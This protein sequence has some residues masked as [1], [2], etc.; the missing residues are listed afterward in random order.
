VRKEEI[1]H[2]AIE[3]M[4]ST[5][6]QTAKQNPKPLNTK[7]LFFVH[8]REAKSRA[9]RAR[10]GHRIRFGCRLGEQE[11]SFDLSLLE[12]LSLQPLAIFA[13]E[14]ATQIMCITMFL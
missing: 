1:Q 3:N 5:Q 4:F 13:K 11:Q 14:S 10:L 7:Y 2:F 6:K 8:P 12:D 9:G